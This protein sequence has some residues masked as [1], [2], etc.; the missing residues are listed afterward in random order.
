VGAS[1]PGAEYAAAHTHQAPRLG[2]DC[3]KGN[4]RPWHRCRRRE[5][6]SL[7]ASAGSKSKWDLPV[8]EQGSNL[9]ASTDASEATEASRYER[10]D[11]QRRPRNRH[12][13]AEGSLAA[14]HPPIPPPAPPPPPPIHPSASTHRPNTQ[15]PSR[16]RGT[17]PAA[18]APTGPPPPGSKRPPPRTPEAAGGRRPGW[19]P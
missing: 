11:S 10:G 14:P 17:G 8:Q 15:V 16:K 7:R 18:P 9:S 2:V 3:N 5:P 4:S 6:T 1:A 12:I 13:G 19:R